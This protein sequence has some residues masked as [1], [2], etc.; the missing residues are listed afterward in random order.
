MRN[1]IEHVYYIPSEQQALDFVDVVDLFLEATSWLVHKF[2][3]HLEL[4][5]DVTRDGIRIVCTPRSGLITVE[6]M[7]GLNQTS[8][9][10]S[11]RDEENYISWM[12]MILE[13]AR[14]SQIA[15]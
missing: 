5:S 14:Q 9:E 15:P 8:S 4:T 13:K 11:V 12:R 7:A 6:R 2:P 1:A 3:E 10:I